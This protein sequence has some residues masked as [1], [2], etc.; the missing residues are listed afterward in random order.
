[1]AVANWKI[2]Y[3]GYTGEAL[4]AERESLQK[5][6]QGGFVSQGSGSVNHQ[7]DVTELRDRLQALT[8]VESERGDTTPQR[9]ATVDF[10]GTRSSDF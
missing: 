10:S 6:L 5:G 1:M 4:V 7:R 8:E 2:I 9:V 3:R